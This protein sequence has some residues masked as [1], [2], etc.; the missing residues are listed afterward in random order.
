MHRKLMLQTFLLPF[1]APVDRPPC[2]RHR[3]FG[4]AACWHG[5]AMRPA[6]GASDRSLAQE[7]RLEVLTSLDLHVAELA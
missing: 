6:A 3:P 7:K 2:I 1:G 4:I 5:C